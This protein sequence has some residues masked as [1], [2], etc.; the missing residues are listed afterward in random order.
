MADEYN[1]ID[2]IIEK[3]QK[4][5][6][7]DVYIPEEFKN[8]RNPVENIKNRVY[9]LQY[10]VPNMKI[11]KELIE[12]ILPMAYEIKTDMLDTSKSWH[13]VDTDKDYDEL[14]DWYFE[15][16]ENTLT[17]FTR[18]RGQLTNGHDHDHLEV[19]FHIHDYDETT[20][21]KYF[22]WIR[23]GM[24]HLDYIVTKYKLTRKMKYIQEDEKFYIDKS[25]FDTK[26]H[27]IIVK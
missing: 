4:M 10:N 8:E 25:A 22:L 26:P 1:P 5:V 19:C 6:A 24:K 11:Q 9:S 18:L 3:A 2:S 17:I 13:R 20:D 15:N 12:E 14:V 21:I 7:K 16:D 23:L 27:I